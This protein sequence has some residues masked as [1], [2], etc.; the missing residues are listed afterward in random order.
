MPTTFT[1]GQFKARLPGAITLVEK[2]Q[3]ESRRI[4]HARAISTLTGPLPVALPCPA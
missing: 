2:G 4:G 3:S 1:F